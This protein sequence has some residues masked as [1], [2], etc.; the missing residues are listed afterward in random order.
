MVN[1]HHLAL[2]HAHQ[3]HDRQHSLAGRPDVH[4]ANLRLSAPMGG[5]DHRSKGHFLLQNIVMAV[6][7][8][9]G[10][11]LLVG[12]RKNYSS[13]SEGVQRLEEVILAVL[14]NGIHLVEK[15]GLGDARV[16]QEWD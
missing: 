5:V 16:L 13:A 7:G 6:T 10:S 1:T 4:D 9:D 11:E 15:P 12:G 2:T 14:G 3:S 8:R